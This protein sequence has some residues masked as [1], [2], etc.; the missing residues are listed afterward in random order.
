MPGVLEMRDDRELLE[1]AL[2]LIAKYHARE[3]VLVDWEKSVIEA[4]SS[5]LAE[6]DPKPVAWLRKNGF[7]FNGEIEPQDDSE[8][9]LYRHPPRP[10]RLSDYE[11]SQLMNNSTGIT[12]YK[13]YKIFADRIMDAMLEKNR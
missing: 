10:V 1:S 11:V 3:T 12:T 6:P 9:P 8:I 5:R 2:Q 13:G 7:R 4:I